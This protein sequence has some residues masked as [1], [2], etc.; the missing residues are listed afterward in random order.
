MVSG[1]A[2]FPLAGAANKPVPTFS[3]AVI[4]YL[5][6]RPVLILEG[7]R[8]VHVNS[9]AE[10]L[11]PQTAT[12]GA[13]PGPARMTRTSWPR[14]S[15]MPVAALTSADREA[16][17]RNRT[18]RLRPAVTSAPFLG[19]VKPPNPYPTV[20][21]LL[22]GAACPSPA[23]LTAPAHVTVIAPT[24]WRPPLSRT[25]AAWPTP[26]TDSLVAH[27]AGTRPSA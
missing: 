7:T 14:A 9:R 4:V 1:F 5:L 27:T 24:P 6:R 20:T 19:A 21:F 26:E 12:A 23:T 15:A 13:M 16:I 11:Q 8:I 22:T 18:V 10:P 25:V 17:R 3:T 2:V